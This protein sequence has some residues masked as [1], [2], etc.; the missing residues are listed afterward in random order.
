MHV[1]LP[2]REEGQFYSILGVKADLKLFGVQMCYAFRQ[3]NLFEMKRMLPE[4]SFS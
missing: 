3:E 2:T 1:Q 4:N